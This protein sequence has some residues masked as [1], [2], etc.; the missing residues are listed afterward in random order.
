MLKVQCVR[1]WKGHSGDSCLCS[2]MARSST[3]ETWWLGWLDSCRPELPGTIFTNVSCGCVVSLL[4]HQLGLG[5]LASPRHL[6]F[7][8]VWPHLGFLRWGQG[9]WTPS[10]QFRAPK[11]SVP[12]ELRG[13]C[14]TF[15]DLTF[16]NHI[17]SL[18]HPVGYK[19][20][21][22]GWC[23]FSRRGHRPH[24]LVRGVSK[25]FWTCFINNSLLSGHRMVTFI[26]HNNIHWP[27]G[28]I[29]L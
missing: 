4:G 9:D 7:L 18:L 3:G 11:V 27:V 2:V 8:R 14:M 19:W 15:F 12:K 13:S 28:L 6:G 22:K 17:A 29:L 5:A 20:V 10:L 26:P 16:R 23:W 24:L 21:T 1:N 25:N